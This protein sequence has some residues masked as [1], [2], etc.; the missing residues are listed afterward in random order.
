MKN[1]VNVD[2]IVPSLEKKFNLF[3]PVN[4]TVLEIIYLINKAINDLTKGSYPMMNNL[5]LIDG[6]TGKKYDV[7]KTVKENGIL[8]G[9]RLIII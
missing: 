6:F 7:N 8:N 2:V 4:K 5:S 9:S 1:K 3:I